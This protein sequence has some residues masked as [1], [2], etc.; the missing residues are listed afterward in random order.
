M[1]PSRVKPKFGKPEPRESQNQSDGSI[2]C[3][4]IPFITIISYFVL[5]AIVR[6]TSGSGSELD[7]TI[8]YGALVVFVIVMLIGAGSMIKDGLAEDEKKQRWINACRIA[9]VPIV[10]RYGYPGGTYED[11]KGI[12][13]TSRPRY[14]LTLRLPGPWLIC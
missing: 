6:Y 1:K 3:V 13:H 5:S 11:E 10:D 8:C 14:R 9:D 7:Q 4:L 12:P 2:G